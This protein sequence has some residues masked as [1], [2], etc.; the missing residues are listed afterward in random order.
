MVHL[1]TGA[2]VG[3]WRGGSS[4]CSIPWLPSRTERAASPSRQP[5]LLGFRQVKMLHSAGCRG[6][7]QVG[8][9]AFPSPFL[10]TSQGIS[11]R[12]PSPA[13]SRHYHSTGRNESP[14]GIQTQAPALSGAHPPAHAM[15]ARLI[16][17]LHAQAA[18]SMPQPRHTQMA[19]PSPW[20]QCLRVP[21]TQPCRG[22]TPHHPC[23]TRALPCT[24]T[25]TLLHATRCPYSLSRTVGSECL[26]LAQMP[27]S[28][29]GH[30]LAMVPSTRPARSW[31]VNVSLFL[32]APP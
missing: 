20:R 11:T 3:R 22:G 9:E 13:C 16:A 5:G 7:R 30:G 1:K 17:H 24:H 19:I 18:L 15:A 31:Q 14:S 27:A 10:H 25:A 2:A 26:A 29:S 21:C 32:S 23:H 6:R 8:R 12:D 4:H 28:L